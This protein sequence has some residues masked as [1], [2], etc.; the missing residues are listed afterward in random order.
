MRHGHRVPVRRTAT[1]IAIAAALGACGNDDTPDLGTVQV[2]TL[3]NRADLV[4]GGDA[5]V[6]IELPRGASVG[7]LAVDVDGRDVSSAF[8]RRSDGRVTGLVT[9]LRTGDN[10]LTARTDFTRAGRLTITNAPRGGPVISG[11]AAG[12]VRVRHAGA[13]RRDR[14]GPRHERERAG[15]GR[16]RRAVQHPD[17]DE[18]V[19]PHDGRRLLVR[20][21]GSESDRGVHRGEPAQTAAPPANPCFRPYTPGTTPG[22]LATTTTDAGLAVPY[23]V[24]VE[25]G[26]MN[27]GIYDIAVLFDPASPGARPPRSRS[28][29][30]RCTTSSAPAPASRVGSAGRPRAGPTTARC[31]AA[32]WSCRTA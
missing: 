4:S 18:A 28:G 25:R 6:E 13:G 26:T 11:R 12:A 19:L 15:L 29:T 27:R 1:A 30:A 20:A 24:R 8:A 9:G 23:I 17:R 31:R 16:G 32:T 14:V 22:D 7:G 2:K 3:S 10:V 21:A 5:L